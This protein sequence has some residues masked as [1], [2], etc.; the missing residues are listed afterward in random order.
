M[1][2]FVTSVP[3]DPLVGNVLFLINY[4]KTITLE[5]GVFT[6]IP[7]QNAT[8]FFASLLAAVLQPRYKVY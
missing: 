4:S 7:S 2:Q 5:T 3:S 8:S 6:K 1:L